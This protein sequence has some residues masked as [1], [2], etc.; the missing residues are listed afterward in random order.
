M[1]NS[2]SFTLAYWIA[3][4]LAESKMNKSNE[5]FCLYAFL[6]LG[7]SVFLKFAWDTK[8]FM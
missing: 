1:M 7:L 2:L 6:I 5:R 8:V 4:A 3:Y